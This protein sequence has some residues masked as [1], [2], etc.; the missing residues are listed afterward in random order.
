MDTLR[1]FLPFVGI[2]LVYFFIIMFLNKKFRVSYLTG[3]W[4]PLIIVV[5]SL[6]LA[7][8]ARVNPQPGSWN[9]L[10]FASMTGVFGVALLTYLAAWGIVSLVQKKN[11]SLNRGNRQR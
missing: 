4:L 7:I 9:D 6:A 8:Y 2:G 10:V 3:L 11:S 5:I 1:I